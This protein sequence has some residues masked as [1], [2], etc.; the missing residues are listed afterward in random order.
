LQYGRVIRPWVGVSM[1]ELTPQV[2]REFGVD[3]PGLDGVAIAG[4]RPGEPAEK[5]GLQRGDVVTQANGH[6]VPS[7]DDLR[8]I[9]RGLKPG[10]QLSLRGLRDNR[11]QT[12]T[13]TLG[14]M[15]PLD[16]LR[17]ENR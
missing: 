9:I 10:D 3:R 5:A 11:E 4:V 7:V 14:E 6:R 2:A 17:Q 13:V 8:R 16:E 1:Q 15:P 12:W